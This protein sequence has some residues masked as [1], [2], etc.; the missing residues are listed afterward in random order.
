V[1]VGGGVGLRRRPGVG[2]GGGRRALGAV[3]SGRGGRW[4]WR[5]AAG[6]LCAGIAGARAAVEGVG[7]G[8]ETACGGVSTAASGRNVGGRELVGRACRSSRN[9]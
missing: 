7:A 2:G 3:A 6:L 1:G 8:V 5:R 9:C 4:G